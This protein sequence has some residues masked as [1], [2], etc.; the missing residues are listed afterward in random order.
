M[1]SPVALPLAG[2]SERLRGVP[3]FPR[4]PGRP[5]KQPRQALAEPVRHVGRHVPLPTR[6]EVCET[7]STDGA[8]PQDGVTS[9]PRAGAEPRLMNV[10]TAAEHLGV[11]PWTVRG[12]IAA[13][14]LP[15]VNLPGVRRV[16]VTMADI[17]RLIARS[18]TTAA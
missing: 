14:E 10:K 8:R 12:L 3:G 6:R 11:S 2:A 1:T 5:R 13:G 9:G 16:L 7:S 18:R 4:R 17:E 15:R